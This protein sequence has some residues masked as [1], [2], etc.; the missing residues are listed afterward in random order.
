MFLI[1]KKQLHGFCIRKS[2]KAPEWFGGLSIFFLLNPITG[3]SQGNSKSPTT[4]T[5]P[6]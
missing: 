6:G 2:K 3:R 1:D 4:L 5:P